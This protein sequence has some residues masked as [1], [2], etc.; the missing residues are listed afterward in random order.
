MSGTEMAYL[1]GELMPLADAK[2]SVMTHAFHYGTAVFEGIRANWNADTEELYLFRMREHYERLRKSAHALMMEL[3]LTD[4]EL[5]DLTIEMVQRSGFHAGRLRAADGLQVA[6]GAGR[7]AARHR[8]TI[9]SAF[10]IPWGAYLDTTG[11]VHVVTSSWRRSEDTS[12]P[13]RA[14]VTGVPTSTRRWPR[15]RRRRR[16][17]TRRSCS[18]TTGM[19]RRARARTS[20]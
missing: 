12:I 9:S 11:G 14:K 13:V 18:T 2:I 4:D 1:R 8:A 5:C 10:L 15:R 3:T 6:G 17:S 20:S 16:A 19:S 7:A